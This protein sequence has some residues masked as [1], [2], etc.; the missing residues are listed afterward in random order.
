MSS[1]RGKEAL[2]YVLQNL[3]IFRTPGPD[4]SFANTGVNQQ[5]L[6]GNGWRRGSSIWSSGNMDAVVTTMQNCWI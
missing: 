5:E 3:K 1:Y 4:F 2:S 6:H